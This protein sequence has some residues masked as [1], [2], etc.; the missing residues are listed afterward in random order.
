MPRAQV[1]ETILT[2]LTWQMLI[3]MGSLNSLLFLTPLNFWTWLILVDLAK[4]NRA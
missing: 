4:I 3:E 2:E 1:L